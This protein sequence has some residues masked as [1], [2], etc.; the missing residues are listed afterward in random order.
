MRNQ[1]VLLDASRVTNGFV[2]YWL[3]G[4]DSN[5]RYVYTYA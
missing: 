2:A 4:W 1:C 5:P 3:R